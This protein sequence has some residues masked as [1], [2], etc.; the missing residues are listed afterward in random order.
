MK[1]ILWMIYVQNIQIN[2]LI[3]NEKIE[4]PK[5]E[6]VEEVK[7]DAIPS[8]EEIEK[9]LLDVVVNMDEENEL[10]SAEDFLDLKKKKKRK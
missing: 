9:D 6:K 5:E 2:L 7:D 10:V 1:L 8:F 4:E 3:K